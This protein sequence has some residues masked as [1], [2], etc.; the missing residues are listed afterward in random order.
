VGTNLE[1]AV[2]IW[3]HEVI[4]LDEKDVPIKA[5]ELVHPIPHVVHQPEPVMLQESGQKVGLLVPL[6]WK[7]ASQQCLRDMSYEGDFC[8]ETMLL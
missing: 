3:H 5:A 7:Q 2:R 4:F 8:S 6:F 1:G